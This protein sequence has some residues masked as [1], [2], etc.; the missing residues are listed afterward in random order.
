MTQTARRAAQVAVATL[1]VAATLTGCLPAGPPLGLPGVR[2]RAVAPQ[3]WDNS[4]PAVLVEAGRTYLF[5][6]TNNMRVP[7]REITSFSATL[8]T[9]QT[10]WYNPRNAMAG[11]PAWVNPLRDQIWAPS[12][13]KVGSLFVMWFAARRTGATDTNND[14]C[15]GRAVSSSPMGLY[16]PDRA[17]IY[18]GLT[19]ERGSNPWGRGALDPEAFRSATGSWYL[20]VSLSRTQRNIGVVR[21]DSAG[22]VV[23]GVNAAPT[24]LAGQAYEWHD[25]SID[26]RMTPDAFL[27]NP[28]MVFDSQTRT[29]L[30]FYSAGQWYTNRYVTGFARCASP[31]GPCTLDARGPF[32]VAGNGRS[33]VGGLTVFRD[34]AGPLRVAYASWTAGHEAQSGSVGEYS[35]QTSWA[36]LVL[37]PGTSA[38]GQTVRLG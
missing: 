29:Y 11:R 31:T 7:V 16:V 2:Q 21:L 26:G 5:G 23:G 9:S 3:V 36:R 33:G 15:I 35:R 12:V 38:A 8:R 24:I 14:Q 22:R 4:D 10:D 25:G 37:G 28:S 32:L 18:C 19:P 30:L 17:P 13:K 1:A 20:L 27:E 34:P 6:S